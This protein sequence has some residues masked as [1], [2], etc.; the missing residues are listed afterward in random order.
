VVSASGQREA[1][2]HALAPLGEVRAAEPSLEDAFVALVRKRE[3]EG[4]GST[5]QD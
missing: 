1:A 3:A 4:G 5:R 2:G